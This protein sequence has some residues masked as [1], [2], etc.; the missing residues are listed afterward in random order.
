[1]DYGNHFFFWYP[2]KYI[3]LYIHK[4]TIK[5]ILRTNSTSIQLTQLFQNPFKFNKA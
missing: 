5:S 2:T 4:I 1:M 3:P